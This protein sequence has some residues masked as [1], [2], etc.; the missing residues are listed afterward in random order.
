MLNG[1]LSETVN[2]GVYIYIYTFVVNDIF[3]L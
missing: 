3:K 2:M 1:S